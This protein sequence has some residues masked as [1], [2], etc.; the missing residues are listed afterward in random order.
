MG[1][2]VSGFYKMPLYKSASLG[3]DIN[4]YM[5]NWHLAN[6][7]GVCENRK[8]IKDYSY[9]DLLQQ[10]W[11]VSRFLYTHKA[12]AHV[13]NVSVIVQMLDNYIKLINHN[14][15]INI[16]RKTFWLTKYGT[17][18]EVKSVLWTAKSDTK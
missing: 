6:L 4:F 13:N 10:M 2:W 14:P 11:W 17:L 5:V 12:S 15:D 8:A 18:Y 16:L 1:P 9:A 3:H 7:Q